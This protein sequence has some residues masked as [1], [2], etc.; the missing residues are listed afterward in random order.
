[1]T[2]TTI[3]RPAGDAAYRQAVGKVTSTTLNDNAVV[4]LVDDG[5]FFDLD[6]VGTAIWTQL[7]EESRFD[8]I[9]AALVARYAVEPGVCA[10]QTATFLTELQRIGLIERRDLPS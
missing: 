2:R 8:E 7:A 5:R 4:M 10:D 1:M 3:E 9:V 6:A